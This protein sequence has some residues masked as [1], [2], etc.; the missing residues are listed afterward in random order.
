MTTG[1]K[2]AGIVVGGRGLLEQS[3]IKVGERLRTVLADRRIPAAVLRLDAEFVAAVASGSLAVLIDV[4]QGNYGRVEPVAD[5]AGVPFVGTGARQAE[6]YDKV[7]LKTFLRRSGWPTPDQIVLDRDLPS[8]AWDLL[9]LI[10]GPV[11]MKPATADLLSQGVRLF[12]SPGDI[13]EM[14][15]HLRYL[16]RLDHTVVVELQAEGVEL[17]VGYHADAA[18]LEVF[19]PMT[20]RMDGP[21]FDHETKVSR[22]YAFVPAEVSAGVADQLRRL[23]AALADEFALRGFFYIN[24]IVTEDDEV[25]VFDAGATVGLSESSYFPVAAAGTGLTVDDLLERQFVRPA[26]A[27]LHRIGVC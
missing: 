23:G 24:A 27:A 25:T 20:I 19:T 13:D 4:S 8:H 11:V 1:S 17:C 21:I 5:L 26:C 14:R 12:P 3:S 18:G 22:R 2:V 15:R 16:F 9:G 7:R 6:I 10:T